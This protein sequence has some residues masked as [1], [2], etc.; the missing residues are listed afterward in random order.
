MTVYGPVAVHP[1]EGKV[2]SVYD[3]TASAWIAL[4][5]VQDWSISGGGRTGRVAGSDTNASTGL[6]GTEEPSTVDIT[7]LTSLGH[8]SW[9]FIHDSLRNNTLVRWRLGLLGEVLQPI[10][11]GSN[12]AAVATSGTVTWAGTSPALEN[13]AEGARIRIG[14]AG[15][16]TDVFIASVDAA[17]KD[18]T[19]S[20]KPS[21]AIT[22]AVYSIDI[23]NYQY[24]FNAKVLSSPTSMP[25]VQSGGQLEGTLN[26]QC[27]AILEY[28]SIVASL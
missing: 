16:E 25:E 6:A 3:T 9:R 14:A 18:T 21:S 23:P 17:T 2:V 7:A 12:T 1:S 24:E 15:S 5:G 10:T 22:A 26:L 8:R 27:R 4:S 13:L 28:P 11:T 20:P 19:V